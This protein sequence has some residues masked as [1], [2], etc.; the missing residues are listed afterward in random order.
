M[1]AGREETS[2]STCERRDRQFGPGTIIADLH[3]AL[4]VFGDHSSG[5]APRSYMSLFAMRKRKLANGK[6]ITFERAEAVPR[7]YGSPRSY[8]PNENLAFAT[9]KE[10][11]ESKHLMEEQRELPNV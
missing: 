10:T 11:M 8:L 4:S 7:L 1:A 9:L 2:I 3:G 6:A 5:F